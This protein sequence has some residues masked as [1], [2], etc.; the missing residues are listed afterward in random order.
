MGQTNPNP[1]PDTRTRYDDEGEELPQQLP[2]F[3]AVYEHGCGHLDSSTCLTD[4]HRACVR[5][6]IDV[7]FNQRVREVVG[8]VAL[9]NVRATV[10]NVNAVGRV[11]DRAVE[12]GANRIT[13][14][15]FFASDTGPA[16]AEATAR[17]VRAAR[18]QAQVIAESLG[19]RLGRPLEV[20]GGAS[21]PSPVPYQAE[22]MT[23]RA[24]DTPIEA[25]DQTVTANV[26]IRFALGPEGAG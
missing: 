25:G 20:S 21:R 6:G 8:Y 15:T 14:I 13:G 19:Y 22:A 7:R 17:A 9:N 11:I 1:N 12:A 23:L 16:R 4:L 3:S 24:A 5:D 26:S 2:P 10:G 18:S